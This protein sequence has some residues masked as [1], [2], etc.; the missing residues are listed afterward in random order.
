MQPTGVVKI[1][2]KLWKFFRV[3]NKTDWDQDR[4]DLEQGLGAAM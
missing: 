4:P 1:S 3:M 2:E